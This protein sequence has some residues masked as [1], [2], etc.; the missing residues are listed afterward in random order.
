MTDEVAHLAEETA[1][2]QDQADERL[3]A[4]EV[5]IEANV[6]ATHEVQGLREDIR[7]SNTTGLARIKALEERVHFF[8]RVITVLVMVLLLMVAASATQSVISALN[9]ST[10]RLIKDVVD[11][12]GARNQAA[13]AATAQ[14]VLSLS[15]DG[16]C[17]N[18][19]ADAGLP[20]PPVGVSCVGLPDN[21]PGAPSGVPP[22][23]PPAQPGA[24]PNY[25]FRALL[26]LGS[27]LVLLITGGAVYLWRGRRHLKGPDE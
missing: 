1:V 23:P 6:Q 2:R 16:D 15:I 22:A 14:V 25:A 8:Q 7:N 20:A 27:V 5:L 12:T 13:Q 21:P 9:R 18:R 17:R 10:V 24:E 19:R 11:P 3:A 26:I 4:V